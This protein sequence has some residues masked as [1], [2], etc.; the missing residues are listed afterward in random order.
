LVADEVAASTDDFWG[1]VPK[2]APEDTDETFKAK[3]EGWVSSGTGGDYFALLA[4]RLAESGGPFILGP[5]LSIADLWAYALLNMIDAK[6]Y[7]H[8]DLGTV[9]ATHPGLGAWYAA[10]KAHPTV[11]AHAD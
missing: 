3:R 4:K 2:R 1:K 7:D 9:T 6:I 11:V 8:I 10:A 5:T